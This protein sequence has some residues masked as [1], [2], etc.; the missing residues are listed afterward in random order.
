MKHLIEY[1]CG[2]VVPGPKLLTLES[3]T[4][5]LDDV[6]N[7][8]CACIVAGVDLDAATKVRLTNTQQGKE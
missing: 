4:Y 6:C 3:V 7:D 8:C 5:I 1:G 2:H